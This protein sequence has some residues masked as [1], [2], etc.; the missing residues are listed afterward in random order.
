MVTLAEPSKSV[1]S[2]MVARRVLC[3]SWPKAGT[4][5]LLELA[6]LALGEGDWY[7]DPDLKYPGGELE[8]G[9]RLQE[10]IDRYE[11]RSFAVK[12]HIGRHPLI[13]SL[14]A[15]HDF[16]HIFIVRDPREVLCS[17][18]RW[19]R[20]LRPDWPISRYLAPLDPDARL[21]KII[22]GLPVLAPFDLDFSQHWDRPL[23]GRYADLTRWLDGP[24]PCLV[25]T[26]EE[27]AGKLG[28]AAQTRAVRRA[29]AHLGVE[30]DEAEAATLARQVCN[31]R[32]QTFHTGPSSDWE[33][34]FTDRHRHLFVELGGEELVRRLGYAPTLPTRPRPPRRSTSANVEPVETPVPPALAIFVEQLG[35]F[36]GG[37]S[38]VQLEFA[39]DGSCRIA[40]HQAGAAHGLEE[41]HATADLFP[42]LPAASGAIDFGFILG[43]LARLAPDRLE[44]WLGETRRVLRRAWWLA[45]EA[46]AG[47]DRTWW[48][49][50]LFSAG[51]RRHP[52]QYC[53]EDYVPGGARHFVLLVE[54]VSPAVF[55]IAP[56]AA[57]GLGADFLRNTGPAAEAAH[58]RYAL[59]RDL[60]QPGWAV[61][62]V[63]ADA[64]AGAK[65]LAAGNPTARINSFE[66]GD[67]A[68]DYARAL[69]G[70]TQADLACQPCDA[71]ALAA[72][73]EGTADMAVCLDGLARVPDPFGLVRSLRRALKRGGLLVLAVSRAQG[74][75]D[76]SLASLAADGCAVRALYRLSDPALRGET[77]ARG[78]FRMV[79]ER[80]SEEDRRAAD[81]WL[82]V[83]EKI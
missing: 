53:I 46:D 24:T 50:R 70:T 33:K 7:R 56:R 34:V 8:F 38:P 25:L 81:G 23:A 73:E 75:S 37:S 57:S 15:Q 67:G 43:S 40:A 17:T 45:L 12:G 1:N 65:V 52:L 79:Q 10:R 55:A 13:E 83:A 31:P 29:L 77:G 59:A 14:L 78:V 71:A 72:Q 49:K 32:S 60:V 3:N 2:P 27:L 5:V 22:R 35:Q 19:L 69:Y 82:L 48:E 64:G 20:D 44:G 39:E 36:F 30:A 18:A 21:E 61:L 62:V 47:R 74:G 9:L 41:T 54:P 4:H 63:S 26:Y 68:A 6:R 28:A 11:G 16:A 42:R 76:E 58:M 51:F 66:L 80:P